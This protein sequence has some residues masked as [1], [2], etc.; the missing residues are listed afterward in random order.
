MVLIRLTRDLIYAVQKLLIFTGIKFREF[1]KLRF[2]IIFAVANFR[3]YE[4][5]PPKVN[6]LK[7]YMEKYHIRT[8][9]LSYQE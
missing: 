9:N 4:I 7:V 3:E 6:S 2:L 8:I 1:R 5:I